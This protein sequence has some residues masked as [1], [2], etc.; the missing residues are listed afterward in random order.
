MAATKR[1]REGGTNIEIGCKIEINYCSIIQIKNRS[2]I[3][4]KKD[5]TSYSKKKI[6]RE[7]KL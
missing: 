2:C 3:G 5:P 6:I 1:I 7:N 4:K